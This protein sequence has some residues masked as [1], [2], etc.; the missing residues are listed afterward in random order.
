MGGWVAAKT[1]GPACPTGWGGG[2]MGVLTPIPGCEL[3]VH[4][5]LRPHSCPRRWQ[6]TVAGSA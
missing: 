1:Q 5:L 4:R 2:G 6:R 3:K